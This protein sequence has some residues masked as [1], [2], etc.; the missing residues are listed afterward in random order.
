MERFHMEYDLGVTPEDA[1]GFLCP[2]TVE[3]RMGFS[4]GKTYQKPSKLI[5]FGRL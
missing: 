2:K 3:R 4:P 1:A 5:W